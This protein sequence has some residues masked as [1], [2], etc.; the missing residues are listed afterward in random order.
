MARAGKIEGRREILPEQNAKLV[1]AAAWL[2]ENPLPSISPAT[3]T[4]EPPN[5][6]IP[7]QGGTF[8]FAEQIKNAGGGTFRYQEQIKES[9][10]ANPSDE[11][12][13]ST[14]GKWKK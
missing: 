11:Y 4:K 3:S 1:N 13:R 8:A 6:K 7:P 12:G 10:A 14:Y 5:T 2:R 9:K